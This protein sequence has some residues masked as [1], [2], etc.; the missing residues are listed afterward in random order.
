[1]DQENE[2]HCLGFK[3]EQYVS[4]I[5]FTVKHTITLDSESKEIR[6]KK[7]SKEN[8]GF[9]VQ[10][11]LFDFSSKTLFPEFS[12]LLTPDLPWTSPGFF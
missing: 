11:E 10:S 2:A 7:L 3:R 9:T 12:K 4:L 1:M 8:I 5:E 6:A